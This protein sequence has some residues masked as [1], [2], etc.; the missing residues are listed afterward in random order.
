M[1]KTLTKI[2]AFL[3]SN[4]LTIKTVLAV[5]VDQDL[6]PLYG[7]ETTGNNLEIDSPDLQALGNLP[8]VSEEQIIGATVKTLLGWSMIIT[9]IAVVVAGIYYIIARGKE[10]EV[11]KAKN[12]IV[13]L[14]IGLAIMASAYAIVTGILKMKIFD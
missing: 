2:I 7:D 8:Q 11:T 9:I 4:L 6:L 14:A 3:T 10:E 12:I 13:Y 1:K 5:N